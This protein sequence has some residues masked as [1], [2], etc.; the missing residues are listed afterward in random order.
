MSG[1]PPD[2]L[3]PG[4]HPVPGEY[5]DCTLADHIVLWMRSRDP[6][7]WSVDFVFIVQ[8]CCRFC[9]D[10]MSEE[11]IIDSE[12]LISLIQAKPELWDKADENYKDRNKRRDAWKSM[13]TQLKENFE[14]LSDGERKDFGKFKFM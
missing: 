7:V 4:D 5:L 10:K 8:L 13:C 12:I 9:C 1:R 2:E 14:N 11:D 6:G 3:Y